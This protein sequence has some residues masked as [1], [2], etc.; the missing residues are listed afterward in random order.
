[1]EN[2]EWNNKCRRAFTLLMHET[3]WK[4]FNFP[5][6]GLSERAVSTCLVVLEQQYGELNE[7][8]LVDF[9]VCQ[10]YALSGYGPEYHQRWKVSH[11]FGRKA[12]SR[13][14]ESHAGRRYYENRWLKEYGVSRCALQASIADRSAHPFQRFI[15]PEYEDHTKL[16]L[17]ST[18]A[19]FAV[20]GLSTLLWTPFSPACQKCLQSESCR[21]RTERCFPELYRLRLEAWQR[22]GGGR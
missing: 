13:F 2:Q 18:D 3:G 4:N 9:C 21:K 7:E 16:R 14:F 19:G 10:G 15:Y 1:M 5:G 17:L 6:G 8:R 22:K 12:I 11:S 20:C